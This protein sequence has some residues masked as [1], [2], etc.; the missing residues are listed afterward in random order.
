L[1]NYT[2][3]NIIHYFV[4]CV[5]LRTKGNLRKNTTLTKHYRLLLGE[6]KLSRELDVIKVLK[7]IRDVQLIKNNT[8]RTM[9]KML[10][11]F[12]K[13]RIIDSESSEAP[14]DRKGFQELL[15]NENDGV[16]I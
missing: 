11:N 6:E 2:A 13:S 4:A 7:T 1:F 14:E 15:E 3:R 8:M 5:C 9:D 12:Q 16:K 10:M